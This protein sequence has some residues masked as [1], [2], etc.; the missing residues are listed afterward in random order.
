M[1]ALAVVSGLPLRPESVY[2]CVHLCQY[3]CFCTRTCTVCVYICWACVAVLGCATA[4]LLGVFRVFEKLHLC[5][6][7]CLPC[8]LC[9]CTMIRPLCSQLSWPPHCP[10]DIL[11]NCYNLWQRRRNFNDLLSNHV[12][13]VSVCRIEIK[14]DDAP[15]QAP[16]IQKI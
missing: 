12:S 5:L 13:R 10:L 4:L 3:M 15:A 14:M 2:M 1:F 6:L 8:C 11:L 16:T 9:Q 7:S